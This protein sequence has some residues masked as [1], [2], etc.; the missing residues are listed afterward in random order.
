MD[1]AAAPERPKGPIACV[2]VVLVN[3]HL[4]TF[5]DVPTP[6]AA[7]CRSKRNGWVSKRTPAI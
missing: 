4:H 2:L 1:R 3:R 6:A 5:Q 7:P